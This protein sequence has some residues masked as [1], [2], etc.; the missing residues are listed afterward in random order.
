MPSTRKGGGRPRPASRREL[1]IATLATVICLFGAALIITGCS[2]TGFTGSDP[3]AKGST[4]NQSAT[5]VPTLTALNVSAAGSPSAPS[6]APAAGVRPVIASPT[7]PA[8]AP[9]LP[10]PIGTVPAHGIRSLADAWGAGVPALIQQVPDPLPDG[11]W[12]IP[13]SLTPDDRFLLATANPPPTTDGSASDKPTSLLLIDLA[14]HQSRN[15]ATPADPSIIPYSAGSD[16]TWVVWAQAPQSP[17]FFSD[18]VL[19]AYNLSGGST[20]QLAKAAYN[21]DGSPALGSDGSAEIDHG[22]VVWAEAVPDLGAAYRDVLKMEDLATGQTTT[23]SENGLTPHIS[24]PYVAWLEVLDAAQPAVPTTQDPQQ[25]Q[26]PPRRGAVV[27]LNLLTGTRTQLSKPDLP[28]DFA[29]YQDSIVWINA[30]RDRMTLTNVSETFQQALPLGSVSTGFEEP[31][32]ND[33]LITWDRPDDVQAWDRKA[34]QLVRV[35]PHGASRS[36]VAPHRLVWISPVSS[37]NGISGQINIM[38]TGRLP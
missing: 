16:G 15:I 5:A 13:Q 22:H 19:Y 30:N 27:V 28:I 20:R 35:A 9:S 36:F 34:D 26:A 6:T 2:L 37:S 38:D 23:L 31:T 8:A 11:T 1:Q 24:W 18:W 4:T 25:A 3:G 12:L 21:K 14:S 33:R 32:L 17:G 29:I 7:I 10:A